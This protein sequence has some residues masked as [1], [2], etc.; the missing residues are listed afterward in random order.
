MAKYLFHITYSEVGFKEILQEGG[1]KRREVVETAIR[2]LNGWLEAIYF[3]FGEVDMFV[4]AELPDNVSAAAFSMIVSSGG[5]ARI[6]TTVLIS[7]E[8]IY[9]ATKKTINYQPFST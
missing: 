7:P 2:S 9:L 5:Q 1:S 4:V 6:K 3:S 8:E